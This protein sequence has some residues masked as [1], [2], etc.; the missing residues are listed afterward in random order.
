MNL[1]SA[2]TR[3][4]DGGFTIVELLVVIVVIGILAAITIVSYT[5]VSSRA[6]TAA[7]IS[8]ASSVQSALLTYYADNSA[9][10]LW[11]NNSTTTIGLIN[12]NNSAR[13]PSG[14]VL[15]N[16][17]ATAG[18]NIGY[19]VIGGATGGVCISYWDYDIPTPAARYL[20]VGT[21]TIA[22]DKSSCS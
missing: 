9:Y 13:V 4:K 19:V 11:T 16:S 3:Q 1:Y 18:T 15:Q 14:I 2:K 17:A 7:N 6:K 22:A 5:G 12:T 20:G 8:N 21:V 10:P